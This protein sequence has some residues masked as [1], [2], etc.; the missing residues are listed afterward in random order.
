MARG[1]PV[2]ITGLIQGA[3]Q[4]KWDL[5]FLEQHC[6]SALVPRKQLVPSSAGENW[7]A[8]GPVT[9]GR[10][11]LREH[12]R[13]LVGPG[14]LAHEASAPMVFDHALA[15][16]SPELLDAFVV[17]RYFAKDYFRTI[18]MT[19]REKLEPSPLRFPSLFVQP[20]GSHCGLHVDQAGTHFY[21]LL[22]SGCKRWRVFPSSEAPL[23]YPRRHGL[24][25][26]SDTFALDLT[27][28][29]L[30]A[31]ATAWETLLM[32]GEAIFVPQ[33]SPHQ[34]ENTEISVA[35]SANYIDSS[36]LPAALQE[37]RLL[38]Q[39]GTRPDYGRTIE[40][41]LKWSPTPGAADTDPGD[42]SWKDFNRASWL[43]EELIS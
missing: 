34:V 37:L 7:A 23:L 27:S 5:P 39:G 30:V 29:P 8:L 12:L 25:Y 43:P 22:I 13:G 18:P 2:V 28:F 19:E 24:F 4:W 15:E 6:G 41:L 40:A 33:N 26:E 31:T 20:A 42:L 38:A 14:P 1:V 10:M 21:Q 11:P 36:G 16:L 3:P 9:G 32:P 17:P 35:I